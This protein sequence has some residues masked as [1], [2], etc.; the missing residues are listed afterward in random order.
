MNEHERNHYINPNSLSNMRWITV[1]IRPG[2]LHQ[3]SLQRLPLAIVDLSL[4]TIF[5]GDTITIAPEVRSKDYVLAR[6]GVHIGWI[7]IMDVKM[8]PMGMSNRQPMDETKPSIST[9]EREHM[10][11]R[12]YDDET[13]PSIP[14]RSR[15]PSVRDDKHIESQQSKINNQPSQKT[16]EKLSHI[17]RLINYMKDAVTISSR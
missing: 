14:D 12:H 15:L 1:G 4:L 3:T 11:T 7:N 2:R 8:I 6:I 5:V 10:R 9:K 16:S 13:E 17:K